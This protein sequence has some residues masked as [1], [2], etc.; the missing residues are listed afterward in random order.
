[1][2]FKETKLPG[3]FLIEIDPLHDE[4]GFFARTWCSQEFSERGLN[5]NL[6][7]CSI[8]YN[9]S[10]GT[11]RG[12]HFQTHPYEEAKLVRCTKG[13][14]FDVIVDL[15]SSSSTYKQWLGVEISV[16]NR[17][18]LYVPEGF[19]HG[20]Q[21]LE[22]ETEVFY[23]ITQYYHPDHASGFKYDDT[24]FNIQWPLPISSI[25]VRDSSY[26]DYEA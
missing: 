22:D 3:A 19:A 17:N 21:T 5:P 26:P 14:I 23:Q 18:M 11:L 24:S 20:F 8:S 1:M 15:R 2:I 13:R 12:M 4:R 25:S 10:K 16:E 7:Q 6:A 9:Y